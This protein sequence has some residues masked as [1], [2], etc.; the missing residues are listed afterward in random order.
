MKRRAFIA[1]LGGAAAAPMIG[2]VVARA[3]Q[4]PPMKRIGVLLG[5][6]ESDP[7]QRSRLSA[8]VRALTELGWLEGRNIRI[9]YRWAS[10]SADRLRA[11]A[12][13][14]ASLAFDVILAQGTPATTALQIAGTKTP[15]VFVSATDP[16]GS[17]LVPSLARPGGTIT[18]FANFEHT[19][20]GKWLEMLKEVAP[21]VTRVAVILNPENAAL[22]GQLRA[23]ET[24]APPLGIKVTAAPIR[25]AA[26]IERVIAAFAA[27][28]NGG[29]VVLTDFI[30]Q[31]HRDLIVTQA[32]RHGL[33]AVYNLRF[34]PVIGGL[35]SYG[36]DRVD[37]FR[38]AASYVDRILKGA[39]PADLPVQH[40][41]KFELVVNLK[42]AKAL[43]LK[44]PESFLLRADEV[45]E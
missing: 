1:L 3:Q 42:T 24:A 2:S 43:G 10:G 39:K 15:I 22:L 35:I 9:E 31:T 41:T 32:A 27:G 21:R 44:I 30:T 33:P 17:G 28:P 11:H 4:P 26:D 5:I 14:L 25:G 20:G 13:E 29:L 6:T 7:E 19:M 16:V 34:F 23:I 40:P 45:I 12:A 38:R 37:L 18:G 36:T 8:F